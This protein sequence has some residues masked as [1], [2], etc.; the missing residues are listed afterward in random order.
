[1]E[2]IG[3]IGELL[4]TSDA[5]G[6]QIVWSYVSKDPSYSDQEARAEMRKA[7]ADMRRMEGSATRM[8]LNVHIVPSETGKRLP[9][10][11]GCE[12]QE[13]VQRPI[14]DLATKALEVEHWD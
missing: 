5:S 3:R 6:I 4:V 13:E 2:A 10:G 8:K 12:L 1:M 7:L 11:L 9:L 14:A